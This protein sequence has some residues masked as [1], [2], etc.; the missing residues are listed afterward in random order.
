MLST[1]RNGIVVSLAFG[2]I[3]AAA[4]PA[5]ADWLEFRGSDGSGKADDSVPTTWSE[6]ENVAWRT[7]LP[8]PGGS[9]PIVV[10][11]RV[12]VTCYSGYGVDADD[13]GDQENL[14]HHVV[15]LDRKTGK[16]LWDRRSRSNLPEQDYSGFMKLH[17][18]ASNTMA[19][20]GEAVYAFFGK[21][22]VWKYSLEGEQLWAVG[23]GSGTHGWGSGTSLILTDD[24]V[25]C[26]ASIESESIL[27]FSK[28][29]GSLKWRKTGIVQSWST[30]VLAVTEAGDTELVV[31]HKGAV[32]GLDP[33]TGEELWTCAMAE[34]YVCPAVVA[35]GSTVYAGSSRKRE[36]VAIKTGGRGDVT[37]T[38]LLWS[39]PK[40]SNVP[41]LIVDGDRIFWF[42]SRGVAAC[43]DAKTGEEIHSQRHS[44]MRVVYASPILV[45]G[46]LYISSC[47]NGTAVYKADE[48]MEEIAKIELEGIGRINA[49]PAVDRGGLLIRGDKAIYC[50]GK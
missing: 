22:G 29:D 25:I 2:F 34:D 42:D 40:T 4:M 15:C 31:S 39:V 20:D 23:A 48:T 13:P 50:I 5:N 12:F 37:D 45:D 3:F 27:A 36:T 33:Q 6:T 16:I 1:I 47:N 35:D 7:E 46:K 28:A 8:G 41:T 17:G 18:Y 49:T 26:N 32:L 19:S 14:L 21:S 11:D 24:L 10:G 38:H 9:S 44:W 43:L 30:P